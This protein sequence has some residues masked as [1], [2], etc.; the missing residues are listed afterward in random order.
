MLVWQM[1]FGRAS[2]NEQELAAYAMSNLFL[3]ILCIESLQGM[4]M[5]VKCSIIFVYLSLLVSCYEWWFVSKTCI[6][7][8][9]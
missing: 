6:V 4:L 9:F 2:E 8:D 1:S 5:P 3:I 7:G